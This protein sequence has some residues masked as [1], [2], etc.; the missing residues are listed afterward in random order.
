MPICE[1]YDPPP[2]YDATRDEMPL[3]D[4]DADITRVTLCHVREILRAMLCLYDVDEA[5][6]TSVMIRCCPEDAYEHAAL[7]S[8]M[9][10][11]RNHT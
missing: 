1:D 4:D 3:V 8:T 9:F 11:I 10:T 7:F 5:R 2:T 6:V